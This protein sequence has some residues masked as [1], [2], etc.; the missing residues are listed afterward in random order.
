MGNGHAYDGSNTPRSTNPSTKKKKRIDI[1]K[2]KQVDFPAVFVDG[3]K[4]EQRRVVAEYALSWITY[5]KGCG[6]KGCIIFDID[7]T[8][9]DGNENVKSGFQFM[10]DMYLKVH[11]LYP[12][13]IVT[14]RPDE[15]HAA[16]MEMLSKK[17]V[18]IP[19]DRLHML[20]A[21]LWG[22]DLKYVERFKWECHLTCVRLHGGVIARFG[23]K[24]WDVAHIQS[25]RTYLK[26]VEDKHCY[27]FF[28]PF[29]RGTLSGKLPGN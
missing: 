25:L 4:T 5:Q 8:L 14:A 27:I 17:G 19:P 24:M 29:L 6:E 10:V 23:D 22:E 2:D 9:I 21:K 26:H 15:D 11:Q 28:D 3:H 16:C 7:D 18:C 1:V 20:P 12:V 13:H